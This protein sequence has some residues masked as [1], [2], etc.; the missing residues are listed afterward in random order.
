MS[1]INSD[2]LMDQPVEGARLR[3][4]ILVAYARAFNH[5]GKLRILGMLARTFNPRPILRL[6]QGGLI[7]V[8]VEDFIGWA[9]IRTGGYEPHTQALA[10]RI[11]SERPGPFID[12]GANVGLFSIAMAR[13]AGAT[14]V[15]IEPDCENCTH[16][17]NNVRLN[18][19][20]N[21]QIFNGAV[22]SE[23]GVASISVR[24]QKN[25]GTAFTSRTPTAGDR[26][27]WVPLLTLDQVLAPLLSPESRPTLIKLDIEGAEKEALLGLNFDGPFRPH[28]LILE[29]NIL[30]E[31][32]W[33]SFDGLRAFFEDRGYSLH[34]IHGQ[35]VAAGDHLP[36]DNIWARD[37]R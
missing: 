2:G 9:L 35:S 19:Y 8:G 3:D 29:Y 11:L 18:G 32:T 37:C 7:R 24:Q 22:S 4:A 12:V 23:T 31:P 33:G 20:S 10:R 30:S 16:L 28:N 36:E 14:V 34:S 13:V 27:D 25:S 17:R 15:A 1:T 6:P 21:V 5:P 26:S